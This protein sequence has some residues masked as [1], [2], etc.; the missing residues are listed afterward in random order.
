MFGCFPLVDC[1]VKA[2]MLYSGRQSCIGLFERKGLRSR[3]AVAAASMIVV[4]DA[5]FPYFIIFVVS[6]QDTEKYQAVLFGLATR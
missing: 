6:M 4:R 2:C 5:I 3:R 1:L